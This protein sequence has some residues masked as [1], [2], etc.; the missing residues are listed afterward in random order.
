M[1]KPEAIGSAQASVAAA[2]RQ[3]VGER[4]GERPAD[5][6]ADQHDALRR[7]RRRQSGFEQIEQGGE[8]PGSPRRHAE[9]RHAAQ[10]VDAAEP[11]QRR[12]QRADVVARV[13]AQSGK[14]QKVIGERCRHA[15]AS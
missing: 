14:Q 5:R 15:F 4:E 8:G 9:I 12:Y 6:I 2:A 1:P 11:L 10:L 7:R 13:V 3:P